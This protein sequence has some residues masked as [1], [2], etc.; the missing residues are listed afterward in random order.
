LTKVKRRL[1]PFFSN[2]KT[3]STVAST[4]VRVKGMIETEKRVPEKIENIDRVLGKS[5]KKT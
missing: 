4:I 3:Y 5:Q 2:I 1:D